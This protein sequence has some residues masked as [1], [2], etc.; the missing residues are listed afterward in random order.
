ME[1]SRR[2]LQLATCL[3]SAVLTRALRADDRPPQK[4]SVG[5]LWDDFHRAKNRKMGGFAPYSAV[6]LARA[7]QAETILYATQAIPERNS[8]F[9]VVTE[10]TNAQMNP[11]YVTGAKLIHE[12]QVKQ[13]NNSLPGEAR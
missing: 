8:K 2:L 9:R 11:W 7:G 4:L 5:I 3:A 1:Y 6:P 13:N 10:R 12:A